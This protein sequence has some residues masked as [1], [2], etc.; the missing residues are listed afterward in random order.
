MD[1]DLAGE[2]QAAVLCVISPA[3]SAKFRRAR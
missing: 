1:E 2:L 3:V